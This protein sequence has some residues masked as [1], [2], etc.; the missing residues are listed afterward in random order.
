MHI[1]TMTIRGM[2]EDKS[3]QFVQQDRGRGEVP[4]GPFGGGGVGW[5]SLVLSGGGRETY[6]LVLPGGGVGSRREEVPLSG[7]G[8]G[9]G[10]PWSCLEEDIR[11]I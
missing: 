10:N 8:S 11:G 1:F 2:C 4:P 6:P 7:G 3:F 9:D 5:V